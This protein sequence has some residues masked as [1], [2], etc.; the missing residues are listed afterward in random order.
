M[1]ESPQPTRR[2]ERVANRGPKPRSPSP[3]VSLITL[4]SSPPPPPPRRRQKP[5]KRPAVKKPDATATPQAP[6]IGDCITLSP[7]PCLSS[8]PQPIVP[9][10]LSTPASTQ[11]KARAR[12]LGP[13][14]LYRPQPKR[15]IEDDA[16]LP[17][18]KRAR[19]DLQGQSVVSPEGEVI[20]SPIEPR[21][22]SRMPNRRGNATPRETESPT[23]LRS[24]TDA[25]QLPPPVSEAQSLASPTLLRR[26]TDTS[27]LP[28]PVS[29]EQSLASPT[30]SR[31]GTDTSHL[32]PPVSEAQSLASPTLLRRAT[33]ASHLPPPV[34]EERSPASPTQNRAPTQRQ[35]LNKAAK[36]AQI[37][38]WLKDM[39]A[40]Y[41]QLTPPTSIS[42][43]SVGPTTPAPPTIQ[44]S[45]TRRERPKEVEVVTIS[46]DSSSGPPSDVMSEHHSVHSYASAPKSISKK[47]GSEYE[48]AHELLSTHEAA[49][50]V[51]D[52]VAEEMANAIGSE[53][54]TP[55]LH[56]EEEATPRRHPALDILSSI[57]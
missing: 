20:L 11:Q 38:A 53:P 57:F 33:D 28:P 8:T 51:G 46:S 14:S 29:K 13:S 12:F 55:E 1:D 31:R 56:K 9:D 54:G 41:T 32:P 3:S 42:S 49:H 26:G 15:R 25:S 45:S 48:S 30:L 37:K 10:E 39:K 17:L 24:A 7:S 43:C 5:V 27:H 23:M 22:R 18:A 16:E 36:E 52:N 35:V 4:S 21:K 19:R 34:P 6:R 40:A 2:S 47:Q 44:P 50:L